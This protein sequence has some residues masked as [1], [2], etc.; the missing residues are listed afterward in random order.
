MRLVHSQF[1]KSQPSECADDAV[2]VW[3]DPPISID[4]ARLR[5]AGADAVVA[6]CDGA[7]VPNPGRGGWG[8]TVSAPGLPVVDLCGGELG[9]TNNRMEVTAAIVALQVLPLSCSATII[10][11]S[12]YLI[13]GAAEWLAGWREK[14]FLRGGLEIPNADLWRELDRLAGRAT[15]WSW[16]RGHNGD[17]GNERA[18]A[19]ALQGMQA[20]ER[21]S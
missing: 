11:D 13:R 12:Q 16:V 20:A 15:R 2:V 18:D 3:D 8:V 14:K 19:L 9:S 1:M 17:A 21:A 7:C 10:S 5:L 6:H 4:D